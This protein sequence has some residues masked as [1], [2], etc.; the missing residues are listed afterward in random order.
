MIRPTCFGYNTETALSN[1]FQQISN[2]TSTEIQSRALKEFESLAQKIEDAGIGLKI[3][4]DTAIPQKPDAVFPNNWFS[5]HSDG[6]VVL[7]P[8]QSP[9]RRAER[10]EDIIEWLKAHYHVSRII[11]FTHFEK[12]EKFLEGTGSLV[13]DHKRKIVFA[14]TSPRTDAELVQMA[15]DE[16]GYASC[17]FAAVDK[18]EKEIYHTNVVMSISETFAVVCLECVTQGKEKLQSELTIA[19]RETVEINYEQLKNFAGNLL[20]LQNKNGEPFM[21]MSES[22]RKTFSPAQI[23][24]MENHASIIATDLQTIETVGGGSARCMLAEIFLQKKLQV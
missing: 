1:S 3:F 2:L 22:A 6:T 13:F 8:M 17:I 18:A 5:T 14:C 24:Q 12:Q 11:D 7:Y 9:L 20:L 23:R 16:L 4:N 10:R 15:A 21:V 19:G